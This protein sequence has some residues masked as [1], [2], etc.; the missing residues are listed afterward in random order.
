MAIV[1]IFLTG[2]SFRTLAILELDLDRLGGVV[3]E[4]P[5]LPGGGRLEHP[6]IIVPPKMLLLHLHLAHDV[7]VVNALP[8]SNQK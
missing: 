1:T 3:L 8:G 5:D 2:G 4:R 6:L 7:R